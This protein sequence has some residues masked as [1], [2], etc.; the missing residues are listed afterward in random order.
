MNNKEQ[1]A[2]KK[3]D[4]NL[5]SYTIT[6]QCCGRVFVTDEPKQDLCTQCMGEL[7][8]FLTLDCE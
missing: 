2:I 4:D 8:D 5:P 1:E 7:A 6:C 3:S